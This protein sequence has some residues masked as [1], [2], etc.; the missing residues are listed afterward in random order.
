MLNVDTEGRR[1]GVLCQSKS[2]C[3]LCYSAR[4]FAS[5]VSSADSVKTVNFVPSEGLQ[6]TVSVSVSV[7]VG[8]LSAIFK[9]P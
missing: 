1:R 3:D 7:S 2:V 4:S 5:G 6:C 8:L 9:R